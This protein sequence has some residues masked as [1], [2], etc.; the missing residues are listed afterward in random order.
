M[1]R[2]IIRTTNKEDWLKARTQDVTSTES[3]ALFG[4]SPYMTEFELFHSKKDKT[5]GMIEENDRMKWGTR[6]QDSI[7]LGIAQDNGFVVER[8]DGY[9]RLPEVRIGSSFD[10]FMEP[11]GILEIKNVDA[12]IFREG[13]IVEDGE[14]QAPHHIELQLQHQML[15]KGA[16]VGYIGALIGG[17]RVSLL[18]RFPDPEIHTRILEECER[19]WKQVDSGIAPS[20]DFIKD[21]DFITKLYKQAEPGKIIEADQDIDMLAHEYALASAAEKAAKEQKDAIRAQILMKIGDASKVVGQGFSI[22]AS[23]TQESYVEAY[24]RA[25][26]RQFRVNWSKKKKGE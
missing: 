17:N 13:W 3:P 15:V 4:L 6:L 12:L 16:S 2:E 25:S 14:I 20:P 23:T 18:Q 8:F 26:F 1:N 10:F 5:I 24:T 11:S 21:A 22:T 9:M 7:A 19:F